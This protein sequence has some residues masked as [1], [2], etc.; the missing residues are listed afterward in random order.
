M[1]QREKNYE[2]AHS[3]LTTCSFPWGFTDG[4]YLNLMNLTT[5]L[6]LQVAFLQYGQYK[7]YGQPVACS[8]PK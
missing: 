8:P 6:Q 4:Q 2:D 1:L 5:S 7:Q 3:T